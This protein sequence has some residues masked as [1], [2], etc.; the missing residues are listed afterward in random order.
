M[1]VLQGRYRIQKTLA[2][3]YGQKTYLARDRQTETFVVLKLL[4]FNRE[5]KWQTVK[6]FEREA[7]T[8]KSLN[9][10][11]IPRYLDYF[12]I[13]TENAKGF[14]LVQSFIP[15]DSLGQQVKA[16]IR[17]SEARLKDIARHILG[18]AD[19]LSDWLGL[20]VR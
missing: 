13:E 20:P 19:E 17:F 7:N 10:P 18:I 14:S 1:D 16:G 9:H 8:L 2:D 5:L 4:L 3:R 12:E 11:A 6:L 15:A